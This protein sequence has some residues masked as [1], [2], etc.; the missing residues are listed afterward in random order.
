MTR[1]LPVLRYRLAWWR[2]FMESPRP[3]WS[4]PMV[5]SHPAQWRENRRIWSARWET[6]EPRPEAFGLPPGYRPVR[7][8]RP[9]TE[10]GG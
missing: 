6:R 9:P 3:S 1:L 2:W 10:S 7:R 5:S 4:D 8:Q